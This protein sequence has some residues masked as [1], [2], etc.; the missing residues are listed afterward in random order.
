MAYSHPMSRKTRKTK[1]SIIILK[2]LKDTIQIYSDI[3]IS[4]LF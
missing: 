4:Q 1:E 2:N 3:E